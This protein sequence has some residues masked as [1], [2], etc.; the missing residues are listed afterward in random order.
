MATTLDPGGGRGATAR[1]GG[2]NS[3]VYDEDGDP[4]EDRASKARGCLSKSNLVLLAAW[5]EARS[6][7]T[8]ACSPF[9]RTGLPSTSSISSPG[10]TRASAAAADPGRTDETKQWV[11]RSPFPGATDIPSCGCELD[12]RRSTCISSPSSS[13]YLKRK[14]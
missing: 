10:L 11:E 13:P 2:E 6:A 14:L 3:D 12:V 5:V 9:P 4:V 7:A 1:E 8:Q